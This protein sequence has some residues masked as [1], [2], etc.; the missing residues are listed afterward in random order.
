MDSEDAQMEEDQTTEA[1]TDESAPAEEAPA[2]EEP[3]WKALLRLVMK[4]VFSSGR[5]CI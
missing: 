5:K 1:S 4:G 2:V 3:L